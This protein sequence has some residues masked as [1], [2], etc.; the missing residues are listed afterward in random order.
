MIFKAKI[1]PYIL[2][3]VKLV[4]KS[5]FFFPEISGK[6]VSSKMSEQKDAEPCRKYSF[7]K[8]TPAHYNDALCCGFWYY[9][10]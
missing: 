3:I 4:F 10:K 1:A 5:V 6:W 2:N 7:M 9:T 8:K